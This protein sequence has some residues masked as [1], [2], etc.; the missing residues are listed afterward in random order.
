MSA[1]TSPSSSLP[2][3]DAQPGDAGELTDV[4]SHERQPVADRCSCDPEIVRADRR[5]G[6][7]EFC[8]EARTGARGRKLDAQEWEPLQNGF[9]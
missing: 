2:G 4:R 9:D 7:S 8:P 1:A 3:L 6:S 5:P